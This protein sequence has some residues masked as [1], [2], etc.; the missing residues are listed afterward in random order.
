MDIFERWEQFKQE[1][2]NENTDT[3]AE[4]IKAKIAKVKDSMEETRHADSMEFANK[5]Y[6]EKLEKIEKLEAELKE[7]T[8]K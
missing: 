2:L 1:K 3:R 6:R 8:S 5:I 7:L 4:K